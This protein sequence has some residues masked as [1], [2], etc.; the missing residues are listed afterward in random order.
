LALASLVIVAAPAAAK[1][2]YVYGPPPDWAHYKQI[3]EP[4]VRETL[5]DPKVQARYPSIERFE[6]EWPNG[7]I[8]DRWDNKGDWP[9]Y[10]TCGRL[11]APVD[12]DARDR[13]VN[14][15][16][17]IDHGA[18]KKVD[19][20]KRASNDI[21]NQICT[22]WVARGKFPP[23]QLMETAAAPAAAAADVADLSDMR[24]LGMTISVM[25]EGAYVLD[26]PA[27]SAGRNAGLAPG[28]V[29]VRVNG[30][31]LAGMGA[32]MTKL[33]RSDAARLDLETAT[34]EHVVVTPRR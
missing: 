28:V 25:P 32:A 10:M 34:G 5:T 3:A 1:T 27:G 11:R 15:I 30:I 22:D 29:I 20:A 6:I 7:Y 4:A 12:S 26:A 8:R 18:V 31:A 23:A 2:D 19:I 13:L 21:R 16:I 17:V 14:F 33:L 24:V 9:G